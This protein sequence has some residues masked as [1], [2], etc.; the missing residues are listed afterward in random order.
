MGKNR[1]P[2]DCPGCCLTGQVFALTGVLHVVT[3]AVLKNA[4]L[5][6]KDSP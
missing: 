3:G 4:F 5:F 1:V 6:V 2:T